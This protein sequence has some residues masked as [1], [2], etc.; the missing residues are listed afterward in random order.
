VVARGQ[1]LARGVGQDAIDHRLTVGRLHPIH[2]GVF[3]VGHRVLSREA[4]WIAGVLAAGL[5]AALSHRSAAA[6]GAS[7]ATAARSSM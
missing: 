5:G 3:A 2:R 6:R 4:Y 7:A 1:L